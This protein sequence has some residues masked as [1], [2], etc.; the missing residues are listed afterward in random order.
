MSIVVIGT[1]VDFVR[2]VIFQLGAFLLF[3][4]FSFCASTAERR[5]EE[6]VDNH[7]D[8]QEYT[9]DDGQRQKPGEVIF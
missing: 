7:H 6:D 9:Q 5:A 1:P 3:D 4:Y 2:I 8:E